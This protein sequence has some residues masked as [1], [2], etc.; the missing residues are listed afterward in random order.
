MCSSDPFQMHYN[1]IGIEQT[2]Q[3]KVGFKFAI[4]PVHTAVNTTIISNTT[5]LI[6]PMVQNHEAIA[7]FQFPVEARVHGLRPHMHLRARE[8]TASLVYPD[9]LRRVLLH[10]PRWDDAWQN[11]YILKERRVCRRGRCWN[12]WRAMTTRQRMR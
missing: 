12:T 1:S 3:T 6:P 5:I 4:K 10:I 9:G 8:G 11:Y 2:D 7:A